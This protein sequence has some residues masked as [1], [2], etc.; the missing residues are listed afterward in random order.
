MEGRLGQEI[1]KVAISNISED[2]RDILSSLEIITQE[3]PLEICKQ[4][5]TLKI[6]INTLSAALNTIPDQF[7]VDFSRKINRVLDVATDIEIQSKMLKSSLIIDHEHVLTAYV[8]KIN[9]E[10]EKKINHH[11]LVKENTYHLSTF[12]V[13]FFSCLVGMAGVLTFLSFQRGF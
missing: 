13:A 7:D 3:I 1:Q 11:F 2:I 9:L 12:I 5:S 10:F 8:E 4:L 6:D